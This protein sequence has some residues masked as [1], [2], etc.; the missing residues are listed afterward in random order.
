METKKI[1]PTLDEILIKLD[2]GYLIPRFENIEIY[3]QEMYYLKLKLK[4]EAKKLI[5]QK[6]IDS[7]MS[8]NLQEGL[9][10]YAPLKYEE[11]L[12]INLLIKSFMFVARQCFD[13]LLFILNQL[14]F[15]LMKKRDGIETSKKFTKLINSLNENKYL[16]LENEILKFLEDNKENLIKTRFFR[17]K[18]KENGRIISDV[19][20][21]SGKH[22]IHLKYPIK[23]I[24]DNLFKQFIAKD[25]TEGDLCFE[26]FKLLDNTALQ[27]INF[28]R[29]IALVLQRKFNKSL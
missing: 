11:H 14:S 5:E 21:N 20:F 26:L 4:E 6:G 12:E 28:H 25:K 13:E 2:K 19:Q 1:I 16:Q 18:L 27:I 8:K 10:F 23:S 29:C 22:K 15:I 9:V 24:K 7:R 3:I 17:N